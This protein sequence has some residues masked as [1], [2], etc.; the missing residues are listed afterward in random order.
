VYHHY[1]FGPGDSLQTIAEALTLANYGTTFGFERGPALTPN[2]ANL[3]SNPVANADSLAT[4][5]NTPL[6]VTTAQLVGND[7]DG[8]LDALTIVGIGSPSA[9][10]GTI[11]SNGDGT[12]TYTP[13]GGFT[14]SDLFTYTLAD[15]HGGG[16][17]GQV[18]VTVN[19]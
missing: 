2:C 4:T 17:T 1:P 11:V 14:G 10:G 15:A 3:N 6:V 9:Q 13:P 8:E 16:A 18:T 19:P 12:W 7:T 5:I